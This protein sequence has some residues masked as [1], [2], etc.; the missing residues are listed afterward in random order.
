MSKKQEWI[1]TEDGPELQREQ[2]ISGL[3]LNKWYFLTPWIILLVGIIYLFWAGYVLLGILAV[4]FGP[5]STL[6]FNIWTFRRLV[7]DP[8]RKQANHNKPK[9]EK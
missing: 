4:I 5:M 7:I 8:L 9:I 6:Y 1:Y 2:K 3:K